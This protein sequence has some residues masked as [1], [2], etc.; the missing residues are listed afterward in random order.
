M[1]KD[2]GRSSLKKISGKNRKIEVFESFEKMTLKE[3]LLAGIYEAGFNKPSAIQQRAI[4]PI[5][6]GIDLFLFLFLR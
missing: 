3:N 4:I 5:V 2:K 1:N 6:N